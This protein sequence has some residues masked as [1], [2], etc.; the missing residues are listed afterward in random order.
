MLDLGLRDSCG[1]VSLMQ[2]DRNW[3]PGAAACTALGVGSRESHRGLS[4]VC[5]S[6]EKPGVVPVPGL[7][8]TSDLSPERP[9]GPYKE[10]KVSWLMLA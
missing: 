1:R 4:M 9:G 6:P 8:C 10:S 3:G 5:R 7:A 2:K